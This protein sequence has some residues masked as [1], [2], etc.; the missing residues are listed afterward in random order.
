MGKG[1]E[2]RAADRWETQEGGRVGAGRGG[3]RVGL[4]RRDTEQGQGLEGRRGVGAG[5]QGGA[6]VE[7]S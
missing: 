1:G 7:H 3:V 6:G 5:P 4:C 2:L